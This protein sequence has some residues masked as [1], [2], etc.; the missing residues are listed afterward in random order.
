MKTILLTGKTGQVGHE[1]VTALAP[2]G[3]VIAVGRD[4][5]DLTQPDSI[6]RCVRDTA[7][8]II[9]NAA[10]YTSVDDAE[11]EPELAMQVNAA[12]PGI[13]AEEARRNGALLLHYS[14]DYVY[15]GSKAGL[16]RE[17]DMPNPVNVYGRSKLGGEYNIMAS[18]CRHLILRTSWLYAN[19]GV[20]F[21]LTI[22]RLARQKQELPV[23]TDQIGSPTWAG[24]LASATAQILHDPRLPEKLGT[25]HFSAGG[26]TSRFSYAQ[27]ILRLAAEFSG[28]DTGWARIAPCTTSQFPRPAK[29]P[30]N[31][32]TSKDRFTQTF[33]TSPT[34]WTEQ[35][36]SCMRNL[37]WNQLLQ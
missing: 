15:D 18:G 12:A 22:L 11:S 30:L 19:R 7:P 33:D 37:P 6:V 17:D 25:Y 26:H 20:N 10:G 27:E 34:G 3:R 23:V 1:L 5:L 9:V 35:L 14:T 29:R 4:R 21:L 2:L 16:Y 36:Q 24:W 28:S 13:I 32:S 31:V 8:D